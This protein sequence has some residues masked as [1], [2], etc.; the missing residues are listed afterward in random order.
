LNSWH[1][2]DLAAARAQ[3]ARRLHSD[4]ERDGPKTTIV[5]QREGDKQHLIYEARGVRRL[6]PRK[7]GR[8]R[9]GIGKRAVD[10]LGP[11]STRGLLQRL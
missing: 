6:F 4:Q 8:L 5:Q 1:N 10:G 11:Q 3:D 2:T 7:L 9:G